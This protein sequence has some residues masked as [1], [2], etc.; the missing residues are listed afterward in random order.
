MAKAL[1]LDKKNGDTNWDYVITSDTNNVKVVFDVL[2]D[3][4]NAP[5]GH[6]F[7]KCHMIFDVNMEDF[8]RK[9]RYVAGGHMI[10]VPPTTTYD[11]IVSRDKVCLALIIDDMNS[12]QVKADDIINAYVTATITENIWTVLGPEFESDSGKKAMIIRKMY[13]LKSSG[14]SFR[15]HLEDCMLHMGYKYCT[16]DPDLWLNPE[17][18]P[19]Y[20]FEY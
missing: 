8:R 5:I 20:V 10:N 17:V 7:V 2:L 18:I 9:D 3:G 14:A 13:G 12:L 1:E 15:N 4:N 11:I 16:D 19:R 6:Q